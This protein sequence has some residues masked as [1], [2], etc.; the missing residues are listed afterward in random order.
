MLNLMIY[1]QVVDLEDQLPGAPVA[2][3]LITRSLDIAH[4]L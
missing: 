2:I 1:I 4:A 3:P